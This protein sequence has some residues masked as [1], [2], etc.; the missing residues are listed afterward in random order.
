MRRIYFA[1]PSLPLRLI[2]LPLQSLL[3]LLLLLQHS[4]SFEWFKSFNLPWLPF[5]WQPTSSFWSAWHICCSWSPSPGSCWP[6]P[7]P[8]SWT[9]CPRPQPGPAPDLCSC[10]GLNFLHPEYFHYLCCGLVGWFLQTIC[11]WLSSELRLGLLFW[12]PI[13]FIRYSLSGIFRSNFS[14]KI[15]TGQCQYFNIF[16]QT[17]FCS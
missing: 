13:K 6:R 4:P 7:S 14:Y 17:V 15:S 9:P 8:P 10:W 1:S 16:Y 5:P 2:P 12:L 3:L 11:Q